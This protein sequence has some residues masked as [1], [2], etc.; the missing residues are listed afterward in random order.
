M[1]LFT[2]SHIHSNH[3]T[4]LLKS[5]SNFSYFFNARS[6]SRVGIGKLRSWNTSMR[7]DILENYNFKI[8]NSYYVTAKRTMS[9]IIVMC[10]ELLLF[11]G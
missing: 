3:P 1:K 9:L 10:V 7:D 11:A 6:S 4:D 2:Q 8:K 5:S